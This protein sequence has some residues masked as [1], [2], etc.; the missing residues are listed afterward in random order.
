MVVDA[1]IAAREQ[2]V[3]L[4]R[5]DQQPGLEVLSQLAVVGLLPLQASEV[6]TETL[7]AV[8]A[9][10]ETLGETG[11]RLALRIEIQPR[12]GRHIAGAEQRIVGSLRGI[13]A[14][15]GIEARE[16]REE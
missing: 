1:V 8:T 9:R 2:V 10:R 6:A 4:E 16:I 3:A 11:E 15:H 13:V 7:G 12:A 5:Q 14:A